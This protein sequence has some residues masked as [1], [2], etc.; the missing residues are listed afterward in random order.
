MYIQEIVK[1][2]RS[3]SSKIIS[4]QVTYYYQFMI[5]NYKMIWDLKK[6]KYLLFHYAHNALSTFFSLIAKK[7]IS[8]PELDLFL[9]WHHNLMSSRPQKKDDLHSNVLCMIFLL[10]DKPAYKIINV[11]VIKQYMKIKYISLKLLK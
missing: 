9:P 5:S 1:K 2:D 11:K 4:Q 8:V 3:D 6:T 10:Y 7:S